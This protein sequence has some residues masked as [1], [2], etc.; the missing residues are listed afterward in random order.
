MLHCFSTSVLLGLLQTTSEILE[1]ENSSTLCVILSILLK[2][3]TTA[4]NI[5]CFICEWAN[6]YFIG[7]RLSM[8]QLWSI[9]VKMMSGKHKGILQM[10]IYINMPCQF[11]QF[12]FTAQQMLARKRC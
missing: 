11:E 7:H 6:V 9:A 3:V 2:I 8:Y 12:I 10:G 4:G 5:I 1:I